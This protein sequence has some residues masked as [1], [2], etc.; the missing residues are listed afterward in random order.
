[1][2]MFHDPQSTEPSWSVRLW[3]VRWGDM[4]WPQGTDFDIANSTWTTGDPIP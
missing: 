2:R 4:D 1:M 3:V